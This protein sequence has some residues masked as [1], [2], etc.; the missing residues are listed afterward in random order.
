MRGVSRASLAELRERLAATLP[1]GAPDAQQAGD[2]LFAVVRLLDAEHG[3]R[4]ALADPSKPGEEKSALARQLLHGR[5]SPVVEDLVAGAAAE[6]WASPGDFA[7][8][9]EQLAIEAFTIAVQYD[10]KLDD[11]EDD[12]FRFAR[13]VASNPSLRTALTGPADTNAKRSL[14]AN[15]LMGKVSSPS[16]SLITQVLTH[17]RGRSPQAVLDLCA[18]IAARRR[19]QLI[20]VVRVPAELTSRQR[21]RLARTLSEAYGRGVHLNV[22]LDRTVIGGVSVQIGDELIDGTA[23]SRLAEVRRKLAG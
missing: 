6:H 4:R 5:V 14:L 18:G 17:P 16:L 10:G 20:A 19:E 11:L 15:L 7:D 21:Q 3:L 22:V 8:A 12:L 9:I 1:D 2:E 13:V 23:A